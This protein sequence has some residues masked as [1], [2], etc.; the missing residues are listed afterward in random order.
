MHIYIYTHMYI[1]YTYNYN[2]YIYIY[3]YIAPIVAAESSRCTVRSAAGGSPD[4]STRPARLKKCPPLRVTSKC[5][6]TVFFQIMT[7]KCSR[8]FPMLL[9]SA[10]RKHPRAAPAAVQVERRALGRPGCRGCLRHS[11]HELGRNTTLHEG[12]FRDTR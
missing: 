9:D 3:I 11:R 10:T 8:S 1:Y 7:P 12:R 4:V 5:G 2:I 6:S